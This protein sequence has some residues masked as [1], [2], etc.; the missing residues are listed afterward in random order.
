MR[1]EP[2]WRLAPGQR[3]MHRCRGGECVLFND[4]S[5]DTHLLDTEAL[6]LLQAL[7]DAPQPAQS[8]ADTW[9]GPDS[10]PDTL[11]G[12]EALLADLAALHLIEA[13]PC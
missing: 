9:S 13:D 8:I 12:L 11:A 4:L 10:D 3:L 7:R 5:G 1:S 2:I 6:E